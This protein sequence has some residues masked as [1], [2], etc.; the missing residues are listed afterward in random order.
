MRGA[1]HLLIVVTESTYP[2]MGRRNFQVV[3]ELILCLEQ[4][5]CATK[6]RHDHCVELPSYISIM[7]RRRTVASVSSGE[8]E[9]VV[10]TLWLRDLSA[11]SHR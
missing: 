1:W 6:I 8:P 11:L 2:E 4:V 7:Q 10:L 5:V 3:E 9:N